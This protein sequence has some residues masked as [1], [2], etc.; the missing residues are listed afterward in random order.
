VL[1]I[2]DIPL[3]VKSFCLG[4]KDVFTR[5]EQRNHFEAL[6][7]ALSVSENGTI[8]GM[9]QRFVNGPSYESL[10]HFMSKSPWSVDDLRKRRLEYVREQVAAKP[11]NSQNI[12]VLATKRDTISGAPEPRKASNVPIVCSIDATFV[13]HTG[14]AIYGV[15]WFR[16]YAKRCYTLAQRLVISTLVTEE[17]LVP[18]GWKQYHR[19]FLDE[20]K[21]YLE[22]TAPEPDADES[23]WIEYDKLIEKYEQNL[24]E[25]KTQN[26]LAAELVDECEQCD[27]SVDVYVCDAALAGPELMGK[28]EEHG[29]AWVSRLSKSR[30]VQVASGGFE[31]IES[32]AHSLPREAFKPV[33]VET[34]H[35][36]R[37]TYWCF[38]KCFMV[39]KWCKL[40]IVISYDNEK[41]EG[42]PIYLI[43]NRTHWVQPE[44]I[45]Q[46]YMRR[47]PVE[48]LIRDGKQEIGLEES[49]QRNEDGVRKHWELSFTAHTF[50]ELGLEVPDLP[51]VPAVR[52]ETIGQ[53]SRVMEG[54]IFHGLLHHVK[55]WVLE[56]RDLE[57][58]I[59]PIMVNRLNRRAT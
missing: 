47:D 20:Q 33:I 18:L 57:E 13:H 38:S 19:G 35:G 31:T 32:F 25:H 51:G 27:L 5:I 49:Q 23:A 21:A 55:Q 53:K 1:P 39:H 17:K 16:D 11:N 6:I 36:E 4:F 30:L 52:L 14:E 42:E 12:K 3:V 46:L 50:L 43:T 41:L 48:H 15:Y 54:A 9:H 44:K 40:R 24:Q 22:E 34:R 2:V 8:A 29:K 58:F 37:R 7:T 28:I 59:R 26:E 56:D 10:H 45:V